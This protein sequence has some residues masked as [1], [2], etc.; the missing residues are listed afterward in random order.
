MSRLQPYSLLLLLLAFS[1]LGCRRMAPIHVWQPAGYAIPPGAKIAIGPVS[2]QAR[3][4]GELEDHLLGQRP[5][6]RSDLALFTAEQLLARSP[7]RLAS[8]A[9][10]SNDVMA[11]EAAR[12]VGADVLLQGEVLS[13]TLN[14]PKAQPIQPEK[15]NYNQLFF[16]RDDPDEPDENIVMSW[17]IID[18]AT[19]Q[20]LGSHL[21]NIHSKQAIKQYPDLSVVAASGQSVLLAATAR[22]TWKSLAPVVEKD[23]VRLATSTF[24]PGSFRVRLGNRLAR[25]GNWQAAER[26]WQ[27]AADWFS[28]NAAAQHNLAVALAAR[29]D[30]DGAKEQLQLASGPLA[31]RLPNE[32]LFWLDQTH[33]NYVAA[34]GLAE[35]AQ[36][37]SFKTP[38]ASREIL[39]VTPVDPEDLPW[40]TAIPFVKPPGWSWQSWLSQP[41][42]L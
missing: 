19:A 22:E 3:V 4:A 39:N 2:G 12:G 14:P 25:K 8:T 30:F 24:Q 9:G 33:R 10:L 32:T 27:G 13:A 36:G 23:K 38:T 17:R 31:F 18:V 41:I 6:A 34:H 20:T 21:V 35:P 42:V 40:W 7:V 1:S 16:K 5:A 11:I 28:W 15:V 37:W 26:Q 29:E